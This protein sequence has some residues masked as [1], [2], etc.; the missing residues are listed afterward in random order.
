MNKLL[1]ALIAGTFALGSI[2]AMADDKTKRALD[3]CLMR[4]GSHV[5]DKALGPNAQYVYRLPV[6]QGH[7]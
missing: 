4:L 3:E 2:A 5:H 6:E 7:N 1:A